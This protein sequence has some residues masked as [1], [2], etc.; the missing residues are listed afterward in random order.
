MQHVPTSKL[1]PVEAHIRT[2]R[3]PGCVCVRDC[4]LQNWRVGTQYPTP[5]PHE[6]NVQTLLS[7]RLQA[8]MKFCGMFYAQPG[9][10]CSTHLAIAM[11]KTKKWI[12][13]LMRYCALLE[14]RVW[15]EGTP[16]IGVLLNSLLGPPLNVCRSLTRTQLGS[17]N[18]QVKCL[19]LQLAP[20][21]VISVMPK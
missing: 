17:S 5:I 12:F 15:K 9:L 8:D 7:M 19:G 4:H 10:P 1:R 21:T 16:Q 3:S 18:L 13:A 11:E 20:S 6:R 2:S 14:G